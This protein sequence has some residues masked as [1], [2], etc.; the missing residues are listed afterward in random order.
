MARLISSDGT[1]VVETV[2]LAGTGTGHDGEWIRVTRH[3][4]HGGDVR[5]PDQLAGLGVDL[6]DFTEVGE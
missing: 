1:T 2:R 5:T 6:A 4:F 3:G